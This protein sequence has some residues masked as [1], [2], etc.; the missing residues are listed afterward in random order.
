MNNTGNENTTSKD[1]YQSNDLNDN[2]P[3]KYIS[4]Y[5]LSNFNFNNKE[6]KSRNK[7]IKQVTWDEDYNDDFLFSFRKKFDDIFQQIEGHEKIFEDIDS[8]H[9]NEKVSND[10][11]KGAVILRKLDFGENF[12]KKKR[13]RKKSSKIDVKKVIEIQRIF[14][15]HFVRDI[16]FKV[17]RLKL[18]QC[19]LELFCLL[20]YGSWCRVKLQYYYQ[21][22]TKYYEA[23]KLDVGKEITF[24]DKLS[25]KLPKCFY[26]GTKINDL[27]SKKIGD[28][29]IDDINDDLNDDL[30]DD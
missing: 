30:N 19:F 1:F 17:D 12:P 6:K 16:N 23:S 8:N 3:Q 11:I 10:V 27:A 18:R 20:V 14:K 21:L 5:E 15:G 26:S 13:K 22:F 24:A 4:K 2:I 25:F 28:D 29:L 7:K 9:R